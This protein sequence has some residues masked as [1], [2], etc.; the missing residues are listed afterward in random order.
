MWCYVMI[1]HHFDLILL[2][3]R[4]QVQFFLSYS[5][6]SIVWD[7]KQEHRTDQL[8]TDVLLV[9]DRRS[10]RKLN[11]HAQKEHIIRLILFFEIVLLHSS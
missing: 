11:F 4:Y 9:T 10:S 1:G 8:N 2:L 6:P 5:I 3:V 7:R